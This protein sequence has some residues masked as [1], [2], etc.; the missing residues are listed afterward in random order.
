M[1]RLALGA[2]FAVFCLFS[3]AS[4]AAGDCVKIGTWALNSWLLPAISVT[5]TVC[6]PGDE[7]VL[8]SYK[9]AQSMTDAL[10]NGE[11]DGTL[12][13]EAPT[14]LMLEKSTGAWKGESLQLL[15]KYAGNHFATVST[16]PLK[17]MVGHIWGAERCSDIDEHEDG[18]QW[19]DI[20]DDSAVTYEK[21]S[22]SFNTVLMRKTLKA[23][24]G[25]ELPAETRIICGKGFT[26]GFR[27]ELPGNPPMVFIQMDLKRQDRTELILAGELAG[28]AQQIEFAY[29]IMYKL[30]DA[31]IIPSPAGSEKVLPTGLYVFPSVIAEKKD[32]LCNFN[33]KV[34]GAIKGLKAGNVTRN[35]DTLD[36][37]HEA[38]VAYGLFMAQINRDELGLG[39]YLNGATTLKN[40][41][42]T[43]INTEA[44]E[45]A[46]R[47][48]FARMRDIYS[49]DVRV[50]QEDIDSH[51]DYFNLP[52]AMMAD[53][54]SPACD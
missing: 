14:G 53:F 39:N 54:H 1:K 29:D 25:N 40:L 31:K 11:I 12:T 42:G 32:V 10:K 44:T 27:P 52:K 49:D 30:P 24:I 34:A 5:D 43:G 20:T 17:D 36:F 41:D 16:V 48:L 13:F 4:N 28:A 22:P 2:L 8:I 35:D 9:N 18:T 6:D 50:T 19:R 23:A 46:R 37:D 33:Q 21:N 15:A 26:T 51:F 38:M 7:I 47:D 45:A 3:T